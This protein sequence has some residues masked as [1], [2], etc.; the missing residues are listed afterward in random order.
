VTVSDLKG[1]PWILQDPSSNA[2]RLVD[3]VRQTAQLEATIVAET[4]NLEFI[5]SLVRLGLGIAILPYTAVVNEAKR[6]ELFCTRLADHAI[7]QE[8]AWVYPRYRRVPKVVGEV[9][10]AFESVRP[11][12]DRMRLR[13]PIRRDPLRKTAAAKSSRSD[14]N[15]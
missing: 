9:L 13:V 3:H 1:Q 11:S 10:K 4:E 8:W 7:S 6:R 12:L 2:R 15:E 14:T 5:K